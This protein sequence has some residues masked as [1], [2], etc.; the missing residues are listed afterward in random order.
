MTLHLFVL[1]WFIRRLKNLVKGVERECI[2]SPLSFTSVVDT[3][4]LVLTLKISGVYV[5]L[6]PQLQILESNVCL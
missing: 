5:S 6:I 4:P 3:P 1:G 2:H